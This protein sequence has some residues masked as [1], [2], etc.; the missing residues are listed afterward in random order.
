MTTEEVVKLNREVLDTWN[1][2]DTEKFLSLCDANVVWKDTGVPQSYTGKEGARKFFNM[3]TTAFPDF[4]L[5]LIK[6]IANENSIACEIEF[7]GTN[8]G[9]MKMGDA[10]EMPATNKKVTANRGSYFAW[11]KNGKVI[12]VHSYPDLAG[13][14]AQLGLMQEA[15][16]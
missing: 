10:P 14:M 7:T 9:S 8:T 2:H 16:A 5:N 11:F 12:E 4:R 15:H 1:K 3:W 13:M 6:T